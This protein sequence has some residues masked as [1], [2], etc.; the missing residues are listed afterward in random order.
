MEEKW[1][2][3][4]I[5]MY[6]ID[7]FHWCGVCVALA[8]T[9]KLIWMIFNT[10]RKS[11]WEM[12]TTADCDWLFKHDWTFCVHWAP[13][14]LIISDTPRWWQPIEMLGG[15]KASYSSIWS[16]INSWLEDPKV[17]INFT[18]CVCALE[19]LFNFFVWIVVWIGPTYIN[20]CIAV[21]W[22]W[23]QYGEC[24]CLCDCAVCILY[25]FQRCALFG[26]I[27]FMQ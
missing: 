20:W 19:N 1:E 11:K 10:M 16:S 27:F 8:Q 22:E 3:G 23:M 26:I 14:Q 7:Q 4:L 2:N 25:V 21:E 5:Y 15:K 13:F 24:V 17:Q 6:V 12:K 9:Y 18:V